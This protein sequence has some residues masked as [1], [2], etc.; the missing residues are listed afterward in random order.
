MD[1]ELERYLTLHDQKAA[2][3]KLAL[4]A[5]RE[6]KVHELQA[7]RRNELVEDLRAGIRRWERRGDPHSLSL[8][9]EARQTV[10]KLEASD[11]HHATAAAAARKVNEEHS[12]WGGE[13]GRIDREIQQFADDYVRARPEMYGPG[14]LFYKFIRPEA[15][16]EEQ[17]RARTALIDMMNGFKASGDMESFTQAELFERAMFPRQ[18]IGARAQIE[19]RPIFGGSN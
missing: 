17:E 4:D 14:S 2:H 1:T 5:L 19:Y 16:G 11:E 15:S 18:S 9:A 12:W 6:A 7:P 8:A 10:E 3:K 13:E